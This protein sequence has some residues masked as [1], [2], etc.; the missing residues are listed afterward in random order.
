VHLVGVIIRRMHL[1][2]SSPYL[3]SLMYGQGLFKIVCLNLNF[4]LGLLINNRI[5][6]FALTVLHNDKL[7]KHLIPSLISGKARYISQ[8]SVITRPSITELNGS[9]KFSL[10]LY[11]SFSTAKKCVIHNDL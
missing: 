6:H 3:I 9:E 1:L 10:F 5:N 11:N 7:Y 2:G 8:H 4:V